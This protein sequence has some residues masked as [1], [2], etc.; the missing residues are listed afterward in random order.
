MKPERLAQ[1][2]AIALIFT[3]LVVIAVLLIAI[4]GLG[5]APRAAD[6]V[7]VASERPDRLPTVA[8]AAA[9]T[10]ECDRAGAWQTG[11]CIQAVLWNSRVDRSLFRLEAEA[12]AEQ[13]EPPPAPIMH[14]SPRSSGSPEW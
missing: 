8:E 2:S 1:P 7:P 6:P 3:A 11:P 12:W 9:A 4:V 14:A 13:E 5:G 10:E